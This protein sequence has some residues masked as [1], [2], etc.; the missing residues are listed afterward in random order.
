[1]LN[2]HRRFLIELNS[3][4]TLSYQRVIDRK[5]RY[6]SYLKKKDTLTEK[7]RI[8]VSDVSEEITL[9][10]I[11]KNSFDLHQQA[12]HADVYG[13]DGEV[14]NIA[15]TAFEWK[16]IAKEWYTACLEEYQSSSEMTKILVS[17][18]E[19]LLSNEN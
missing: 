7:E 13:P 18:I 5:I 1:M 11:L 14:Q 19:K 2:V 12:F 16:E 4:T 8:A 6:L 9:I 15:S 3:K 17:T 10:T